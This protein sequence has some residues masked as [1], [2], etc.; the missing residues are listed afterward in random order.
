[1]RRVARACT[2]LRLVIG[3]L[4]QGTQ[5][6]GGSTAVSAA[7]AD[8]VAKAYDEDA[9]SRRA[10]AAV[11]GALVADAATMGLHWIYDLSQIQK[12]LG[13]SEEPAFFE[14]PSCPYYEY[15]SG[16]QSPYGD[17]LM[18]VLQYMTSG[19]GGQQ[20]GTLDG[21]GFAKFLAEFYRSYRGRLNKSSRA[22]MEAVLQGGRNWPEC[23]DPRDSQ[24]NNFVKVVPIVARY[25]G[26]PGL[27]KAV[28][29]AVRAQQNSDEAVAFAVAAALIL[30]RVVLGTHN[31]TAAVQWA[32]AGAEGSGTSLSRSA[33]EAVR[34]VLVQHQAGTPMR[35]LLYAPG[36]DSKPG[37]WGPSCANPGALQGALLAAIQASEAPQQ[38]GG[39]SGG[40]AYA[41]GVR[42]NMLLG[43][44]NCSR[45]VLLG[46]LLAAQAGPAAIPS[47][48][49]SKTRSYDSSD[50]L[51]GQL[52]GFRAA[53]RRR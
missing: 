25:A 7:V 13:K 40:T 24:A 8:D 53:E 35:E 4:A 20:E 44:D 47:A 31:V 19:P 14:P 42:T 5:V 28:D 17:E 32:A 29:A 15:E 41:R 21:S 36:S 37:R 43:G 23:G 49:R 18:P 27:V 33:L 34:A 39:G 48:W 6:V 38:E 50:V 1:M 11:L 3:L 46:A 2:S 45:S 10:A 12:L 26:Q 52:L 22:M 9:V 30:E 16:V 51:V